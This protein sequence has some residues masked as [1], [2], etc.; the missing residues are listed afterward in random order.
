MVAV[1]GVV[2]CQGGCRLYCSSIKTSNGQ[3]LA[4]NDRVSFEPLW[5]QLGVTQPE[6]W[7]TRHCDER[8]N[9]SREAPRAHVWVGPVA[10]VGARQRALVT[11][12]SSS[13]DAA[14]AA[15]TT[16]TLPVQVGQRLSDQRFCDQSSIPLISTTAARCKRTQVRSEHRNG[17]LV[18]G[19]IRS[20]VKPRDAACRR[21]SGVS[22]VA[23]KSA[24]SFTDINIST[25]LPQ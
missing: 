11:Q 5:K 3:A 16:A 10:S 6:R 7:W 18:R 22:G 12:C 17:C 19:S 23:T 2:C 9:S 1:H 25:R 24:S 13:A 14:D 15:V 21:W 20:S 8:T 4:A